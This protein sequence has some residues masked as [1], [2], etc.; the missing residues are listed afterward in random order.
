MTP[1][2]SWIKWLV[3]ISVSVVVAGY[4]FW[5]LEGPALKRGGTLTQYLRKWLGIS[6]YRARRRWTVPALAFLS[7]AWAGS[8]VW[9]FFHLVL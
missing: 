6:P 4:T 1:E 2:T 3:A 7:A 9:L 5:R 8:V